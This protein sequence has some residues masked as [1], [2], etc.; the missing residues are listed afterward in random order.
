MVDVCTAGVG[1]S[2]EFGAEAL[3]PAASDARDVRNPVCGSTNMSLD[4][5]WTT[6]PS[7]VVITASPRTAEAARADRS[8][9]VE[10]G[11]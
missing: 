5:V 7:G 1:G 2:D 10:R 9:A 4:A 6:R 3:F 11:S 8:D